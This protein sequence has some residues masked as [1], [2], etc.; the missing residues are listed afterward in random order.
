[1]KYKAE[2]LPPLDPYKKRQ[3]RLQAK[4]ANNE[5]FSFYRCE[6]D[7]EWTEFS[8]AVRRN[9]SLVQVVDSLDGEG[10]TYL[11]SDGVSYSERV[12]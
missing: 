11:L 2:Q 6:G 8:S 10:V 4:V 5:T 9:S 3:R 7:D 1:M 12:G